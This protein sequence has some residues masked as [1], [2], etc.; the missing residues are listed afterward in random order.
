[1]KR[2]QVAIRGSHQVGWGGDEDDAAD[3][4]VGRDGRGREMIVSPFTRHRDAGHRRGR[5]EGHGSPIP[6]CKGGSKVTHGPSIRERVP[7]TVCLP[8]YSWGSAVLLLPNKRRV[9]SR[10][11][12]DG[13]WTLV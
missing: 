5:R 7:G 9:V 8:G 13:E 6:G 4:E 3:N 11:A 2:G 10:V 12:I 1:M